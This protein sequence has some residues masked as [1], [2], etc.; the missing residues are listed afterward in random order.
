MVAGALR[1]VAWGGSP[2]WWGFLFLLVALAAEGALRA[3]PSVAFGG[4][5]TSLSPDGR[6]V[7]M[8]YQGAIA[9]LELETSRLRLLSEGAGWDI[10][11][12][13]DPSGRQIW[14]IRT[15]DA[16][17]GT[18]CMLDLRTSALEERMVRARGPLRVGPRGRMIYGHFAS[19]G[20]PGRLGRYEIGPRRVDGLEGFPVKHSTA[21]QEGF[22]LDR[23]GGSLLYAVHA[24]QP[25]EQTG[26][27]GPQA[28]LWQYGIGTGES[29]RLG[30]V[31]SRVF[32]M[33]AGAAA[34]EV[35]IVSDWGGAH[36]NLWKVRFGE[37][38]LRF[39]RLSSGLADEDW[40][41]LASSGRFLHTDNSENATRLVVQE[42]EAG[43][44][45]EVQLA[46]I[47]FGEPTK[48][49]HLEISSAT[50]EREDVGRISIRRKGGRFYFPM[51]ALYRL[52]RGLG[53]FYGRGGETLELPH[54]D[55]ELVA[56]KGSEFREIRRTFQVGPGMPTSVSIR[57]ERWHD[58][59]KENWYSGEN[60]IHANYGYGA[61][62]SDVRTVADQVEGEGLNVANL[63]VAN[64][65]GDGVFDRPFFLGQAD[66]RS[67]RDTILYWNEEFRSTIW[68]HL[69]LAAMNQLVEPIFT[70]FEG[71]TNP[72]DV[73]TNAE[74]AER[75]RE[76]GASVSYTHPA[77]SAEDPYQG[78]YSAKGLPVDA[79]LGVVDTL[80]VLGFGYEGSLPLWYRLLNCGFRIPAAAGT[81][82]FLNRIRGYPP[83]WGRCYV[84]IPGG[85]DYDAW[86]E[87]QREGRSF[88]TTGPILDF[89]VA[90][91]PSGSTV[92]LSSPGLVRVSLGVG[93]QYS[94][95]GG[96]VIGNGK[97]VSR[98]AVDAKGG[99]EWSHYE[100]EVPVAHS[101]WLAAR[102]SGA[103]PPDYVG[104]RQVAH[105]NP[106]YISVSGTG[107]SP[108][109]SPAYFLQWIDRL[110]ADLELR[111]RFRN[112][113]VEVDA[114]LERAR[115]VY[116]SLR[117]AP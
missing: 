36:H 47:D 84:R 56:F 26:N 60:H 67:T 1:P 100:V 104:G 83:G 90:G 117:P 62:Y 23:N 111:N 38:R 86:I 29:S 14:F 64:S 20:F 102:V 44:R 45:R 49:V 54:G 5:Q 42:S 51:G 3:H 52:T 21:V 31:P 68:G 13:W 70:G 78:A 50:G 15:Q 53:H 110:Q 76:Q 25:G 91:M 39:D 88:V 8:S 10:E 73:P 107:I 80:D 77:R 4:I 98:I 115:A 59:R 28:Q 63:V 33:T 106:V 65:D 57:F 30:E 7:A 34:N 40:P 35:V 109:D 85:L 22:T 11:P 92:K 81:D 79:A 24:D 108:G 75:A 74:V 43:V 66:G 101:G 96:E 2:R 87:G 114:Q 89:K 61:W 72:W 113:K 99:G 27:R 71:T 82:C 18:L 9:L 37:G 17:V 19:R 95:D 16:R 105:A 69:T 97:V 94:L 46:G 41:S 58:P 103:A 6:S 48:A 116:R 12:A 55:Y 32:R 112:R 93:S